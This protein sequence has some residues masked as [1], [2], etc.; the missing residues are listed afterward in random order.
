M[1]Q[2]RPRPGPGGFGQTIEGAKQGETA[3]LKRLWG[4]AGLLGS[5]AVL[6][7][8]LEPT[9]TLHLIRSH[10]FYPNPGKLTAV[11]RGRPEKKP[12]GRGSKLIR[13]QHP[14]AH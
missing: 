3:L 7:S 12:W 9:E 6:A 11:Q 4:L 5:P 10:Q 1:W 8:G 2:P 14:G 13:R